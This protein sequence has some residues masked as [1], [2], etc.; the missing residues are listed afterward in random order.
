MLKKDEIKVLSTLFSDLTKSFTIMDISKELN[1]KYVQTYRTIQSLVKSKDISLESIGKSKVVKVDLTRFNLNYSIVEIERTK[2]KLT[3]KELR[4]I[5]K[6]IVDLNENFVCLLFGSQVKKN[7]LKADFDLLFV[8]PNDYN[9]DLFEKKVKRQLI[10]Y[11]CDINIV[12]EESLLEMWSRPKKI[13]VG[14]EILKN[15][16]VL[17]N[18]EHFINLLKVHYIG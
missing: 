16:L 8:I 14:N 15:H 6:R 18:S 11:N 7:S 2:I 4:I 17:Y 1:Q 3:N 12:N 9:H 10:P 5:H 13:N